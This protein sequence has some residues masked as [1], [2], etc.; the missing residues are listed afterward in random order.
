MPAETNTKRLLVRQ[1]AA[2]PFAH[3]VCSKPP[4]SATLAQMLKVAVGTGV[5]VHLVLGAP[6]GM[7]LPELV[8]S[9]SRRGVDGW[10]KWAHHGRALVLLFAQTDSALQ[11]QADICRLGKGASASKGTVTSPAFLL[12][13]EVK[14]L[15]EQIATKSI[16][17]CSV[18]SILIFAFLRPEVSKK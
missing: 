18:T 14:F 5:G 9:R 1:H 2:I 11:R 6:L 13:F 17:G 16:L 8:D 7:Q 10:T 4:Q 12:S 3:P 15:L